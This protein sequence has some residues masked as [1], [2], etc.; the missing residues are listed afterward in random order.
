MAHRLML[1][2]VGLDLRAVQRD[3]LEPEQ[4]GAVTQCEHLD[5]EQR[6]RTKVSKPKLIDHGV[7][8]ML[9]A[10]QYPKVDPLVRR[11]SDLPRRVDSIHV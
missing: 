5:T 11:R 1:R 4:S 9:V 3:V 6:Q 2:G 10:G 7:K 8:R